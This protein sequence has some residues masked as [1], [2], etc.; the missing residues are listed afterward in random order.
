VIGL[1]LVT[2]LLLPVLVIGSI[3]RVKSLWAGRRGPPLLQLAFDL[4]RLVRKRPVCSQTTSPMFRLAPYVVLATTLVSGLL[5]PLVGA[6]G[7]ISF[8]YDFVW[9]AY[10][11]ALG[12]VALML[13]ALDT[14]SAFEGM[15]ASREATFAALLEPALFLVVGA[16]ALETNRS[17]LAGTLALRPDSGPSWVI[18]VGAIVALFIVVQVEAARV[19]VDDPATHLELTMI[20][21]VMILDHSGRELAALQWS[22]AAKLT[23]GLSIVAALINPVPGPLQIVFTLLL[24]VLLGCIESLIARL[25]L[26]AVP[27]YILI[28]V[29]AASVALLATS[30]QGGAG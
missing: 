18:W 8:A 3:N 1:H 24:A 10:V 7:P 19:P 13:G 11:W 12:R 27:Q 9:F 17:T 22:A 28:G 20:H 6:R 29:V 5:V 26:N 25:K 14:G 30:W 16:L 21:E 15:G 23:L 4:L 2:L